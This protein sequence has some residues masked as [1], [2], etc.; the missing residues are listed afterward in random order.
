MHARVVVQDI[1]N[2]ISHSLM[3]FNKS[4]EDEIYKPLKIPPK[5]PCGTNV[6]EREKG[7]K[8]LKALLPLPLL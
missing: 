3:L 7:R 2:P 1:L 5:V 6:I 8:G 4:K